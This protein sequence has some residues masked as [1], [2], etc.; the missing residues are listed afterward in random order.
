MS[1]HLRQAAFL[2]MRCSGDISSELRQYRGNAAPVS[3]TRDVSIDR[4]YIHIATYGL[5]MLLK[6]LFEENNDGI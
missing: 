3:S 5:F 4:I 6:G 1:V 2:A